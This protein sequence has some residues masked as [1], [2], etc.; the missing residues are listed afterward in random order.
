MSNVVQFNKKQT[1]MLLTLKEASEQVGLK[2]EHL[3]K[4]TVTTNDI[5]YYRVG[6][7]PMVR[8][9]DILTYLDNCY[10]RSRN[11]DSKKTYLGKW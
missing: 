7:K 9:E 2:Y 10:V 4:L 1:K 8:L 11:Y 3:Y 5:P 6:K